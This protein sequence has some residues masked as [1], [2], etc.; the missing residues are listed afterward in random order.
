VIEMRR[1]ARL[2]LATSIALALGLGG[3]S[4]VEAAGAKPSCKST[5]GTVKFA[6]SLPKLGNPKKVVTT[7]SASA[8]KVGSCAGGGVASA[9]ATLNAKFAK[10]GNCTTFGNGVSNSA[11]GK[12]VL[13]W[14][15]GE[16]STVAAT[17]STVP[18]KPTTLKVAGTVSVGLFKGAKVTQTVIYTPVNGGCTKAALAKATFKQTAPL[19]IK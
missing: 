14:N 11:S 8:V 15:T 12:L 6:P 2:G 4:P 5:V 1:I 17:L 10:R 18:A 3:W 9:T 7:M 19:V 16:S 13:I